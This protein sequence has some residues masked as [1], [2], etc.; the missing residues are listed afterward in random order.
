[1][2]WDYIEPVDFDRYEVRYRRGSTIN[3]ESASTLHAN[4]LTAKSLTLDSVPVGQ[5]VVMVKAF[6]TAGNE[7][8]NPGTVLLNLG[9]NTEIRLT[10]IQR[11]DEHPGWAGILIN[12]TVSAGTLVA[13]INTTLFWGGTEAR[14]WSEGSADIFGTCHIKRCPTKLR[15]I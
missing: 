14:F 15:L 11:V 13:D 8:V 12:G 1:V 2:S 10:E 3:W 7:S 6:D 9:D 4:K 5:G